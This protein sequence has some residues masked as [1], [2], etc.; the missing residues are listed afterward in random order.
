MAR[1]YYEIKVRHEGLNKYR[2]IRGQEQ[3]IVNQKARAQKA[4]WDE[5]WRRVYERYSLNRPMEGWKAEAARRTVDAQAAL[6]DADNILGTSLSVHEAVDWDALKDHSNFPVPKPA[7]PLLQNLVP[8][9]TKEDPEHQVRLNLIDQ[10]FSSHRERKIADAEARFQLALSNWDRT[11]KELM[12][13]NAENARRHRKEVEDWERQKNAFEKAQAEANAVVDGLQE[14]YGSG[15]VEAIEEYCDLVLSNSF[16]PEWCPKNFGLRF[17]PEDRMLILDFDLPM[18]DDLP[19]LKEVKYIESS[20]VLEEVY[21]EEA[22]KG[23]IY[24]KLVRD[25]CLRNLHELFEADAA[26]HI[27]A[28]TFNGWVDLTHEA[29][30]SRERDCIVSVQTTRERF[31]SMTLSS[32]G[33]EA[34]FQALSG[35]GS[36]EF[37]TLTSVVPLRYLDKDDGRFIGAI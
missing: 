34:C 14:R 37:H 33:S 13:Q 7:A 24:D 6:R 35:A 20:D 30:G 22:E 18:P 29:T 10:L 25:I 32:V 9:P 12:A 3:S 23:R 26:G 16:Y 15:D 21:L 27:D 31:L 28:I 8:E 36:G 1:Q 4:Q 2:H 19:A 5:Q 17:N 11:V